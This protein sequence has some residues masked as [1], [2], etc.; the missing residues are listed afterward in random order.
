[1]STLHKLYFWLVAVIADALD[2]VQVTK[3]ESMLESTYKSKECDDKDGDDT[4]LH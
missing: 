4:M 2:G 3:N 1:M